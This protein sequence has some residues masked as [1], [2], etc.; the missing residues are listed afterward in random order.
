[1]AHFD[2]VIIGQGLAG[3][4]LAW[5]L[6]W[7]QA[8]VLVI[9][10]ESAVTSSKVA[11]GLVTPITGARLAVTWR[12]DP[13]LPVAE[14][15]YR[16]VEAET[17]TNCYHLRQS[18]RLFDGPADAALFARKGDQLAGLVA[19]PDPPPDSSAFVAPHGEFAMPRAARLDV[20]AYL[21]ASRTRF[22][23]DGGYIA[24]EVAL[25]GD[26][27]V[28]PVGIRL[29][30]YDVTAEMLVFCQGFDRVPNPWFPTLPFAPAKGEILT[31]RV[32]GLRETRVVHGHGVWL[33]PVGPDSYRVGATYNTQYP[34][35]SPTVEGRDELLGKLGR[36]L[37]MPWEVVAHAAAVRPV[38]R[39]RKPRL[40]THPEY[41]R[42]AVFNGLG[43]KGALTAPFFAAMLADHLLNGSPIEAE[44]DLGQI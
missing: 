8:R 7:R 28:S 9:D 25:P 11:A 29:P 40:G 15:F 24:A 32:P 36:F 17:G 12:I 10:R 4:A 20:P 37:R 23:A 43:S 35:D 14:T 13:L 26:I 21:G 3:T 27:E 18:V 19:R 44:V 42:L 30:K 39:S 33:A 1:M 16:R 22:A 31:V 41:P 38:L 34:D 6:R 2:A 5:A